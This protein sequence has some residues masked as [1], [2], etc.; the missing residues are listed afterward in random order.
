MSSIIVTLKNHIVLGYRNNAGSLYII[1]EKKT[2]L[3]MK[4]EIHSLSHCPDI[5]TVHFV[6]FPASLFFFF[7]KLRIILYVMFCNLL[8]SFMICHEQMK[9]Y[10]RLI[11]MK[12][13]RA[14]L[15]IK[16]NANY[17]NSE[18]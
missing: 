18:T 14:S 13:C 7:N 12:R 4:K 5:P 1:W 2:S 3:K 10:K 8:L 16:E 6:S 15:A 9:K 11:N 17:N